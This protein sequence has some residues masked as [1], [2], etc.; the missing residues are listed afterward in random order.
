MYAR[1]E[2]V[3]WGVLFSYFILFFA[4]PPGLPSA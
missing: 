3:F 4:F 1:E 2:Y